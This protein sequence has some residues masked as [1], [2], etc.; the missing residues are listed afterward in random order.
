MIRMG[1]EFWRAPWAVTVGIE[2]WRIKVRDAV[3][4]AVWI[5]VTLDGG[6]EEIRTEW[7]GLLSQNG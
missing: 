6:A 7:G 2:Y 3:G 5:V 4:I 1:V